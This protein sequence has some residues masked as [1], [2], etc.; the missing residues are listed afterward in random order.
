L[1]F[2]VASISDLSGNFNGDGTVDAAIYVASRKVLGA[3]YTEDDF[4]FWRVN[5]DVTPGNGSS[6]T[7]ARSC[8]MC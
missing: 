6:L 4:K 2:R 5:F 8:R 7:A 1:V 3:I